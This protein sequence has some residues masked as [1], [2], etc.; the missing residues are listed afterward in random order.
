V[1]RELEDRLKRAKIDI[2]DPIVWSVR[3]GKSRLEIE[4][5]QHL[6]T[7]SKRT[8]W[9][10]WTVRDQYV[11]IVDAIGHASFLRSRVSSHRLKPSWVRM[12]SPYD[13]A[14]VQHLARRLF[15]ETLGY[16]P[17]HKTRKQRFQPAVA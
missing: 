2:S 6:Y 3:G 5:P 8:P 13:V 11:E 14:S 1:K 10:K 17:P 7:R 16:W 9:T 12:L 15:L 4:R